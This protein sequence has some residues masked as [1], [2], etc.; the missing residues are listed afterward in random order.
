[1]VGIKE[2]N[3]VTLYIREQMLLMQVAQVKLSRG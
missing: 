3:N 1:M 2:W